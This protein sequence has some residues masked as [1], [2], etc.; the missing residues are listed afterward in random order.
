MNIDHGQELRAVT[1]PDSFEHGH[2][3]QAW[4][5]LL[6]RLAAERDESV[7]ERIGVAPLSIRAL[8]GAVHLGR[9][10]SPSPTDGPIE[11]SVLITPQSTEER[12][13]RLVLTCGGSGRVSRMEFFRKRPAVWD[14]ILPSSRI[15]E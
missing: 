6:V 10:V 15:T 13:A 1:D 9:D 5:D 3:A 8:V 14:W 7:P 4:F 2:A 11:G 12:W